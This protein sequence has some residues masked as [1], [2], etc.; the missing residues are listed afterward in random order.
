MASIEIR[1]PQLGEGLQEARLV[2]FLKEPGQPVRRDE[3]IY[4]MET[5]KAVMEIEA[6]TEGVLGSWSANVD[7]VLPIGAVIGRIETD[8]M[9]AP[10]AAGGAPDAA[11]ISDSPA[12]R[13][14]LT[15][16][17]IPQLG[18]GLQEARI[19]RFLKMPGDSVE[20]DEPIYEMETDKAVMEIEAPAAGILE[21]WTA[22]ADDVL[23][24]GARIGGIRT[25][26][27]VDIAGGGTLLVSDAPISQAPAPEAPES[28][29]SRLE[30]QPVE[31][32]GEGSTGPLRNRD[33]SPR[34]RAYAYQKG[35][36]EGQL[37]SLSRSAA[38]RLTQADIDRFLA[39]GAPATAA[40]KP[41]SADADYRESPLPARQKTL[42]FR[43]QRSA[44][45]VVPA[46]MEMAMD[47][48]RIEAERARL[49]QERGD[50]AP[51]QFV[52][53]AWCVTQA[54][55]DHPRFLSALANE[56]TVRQY[57][58][59][60]LGIAVA[61]END[62]LLM[63]RVVNASAR[64][65]DEFVAASQDAIRRA[66][67]GEDQTAEAMQLSLTSMA[68]VGVT[69][70]IPVVVAPSVGTLF[71][72]APID[73]AYPLPGGGIAFRRTAK[74]VLTFDHRIVN[75][76]GAARFLSDVRKRVEEINL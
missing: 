48:S 53:F 7:D 56:T 45:T 1:I 38:G 29:R 41:K 58:N 51:S 59:L 47:W 72:G 15:D 66:R 50:R 22:K 19:V 33:V 26:T 62:E 25:E 64:T 44:Q 4:E 65:F 75:G 2:R 52:M 37:L 30:A 13:P 54:A 49:K 18:E 17:R 61:R 39:Q 69:L 63:A 5:D 36:T 73:E 68:G 14:S 9:P 67:D 46:T 12:A 24:I 6:P 42:N 31:E 35:M 28:S 8:G 20:R 23:P 76:V 21:E 71:I 32:A 43:L 34:T 27:A 60:H 11:A 70:G 16:I 55:K 74:M 3:P 57:E 10:S 40:S